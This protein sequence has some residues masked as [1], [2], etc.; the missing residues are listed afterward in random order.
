MSKQ[1]QKSVEV[2]IKA[3]QAPGVME[4]IKRQSNTGVKT[5]MKPSMLST[6]LDEKDRKQIKKEIDYKGNYGIYYTTLFST[7]K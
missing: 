1:D 7:S 3:L 6:L 2:L 4:A 5:D